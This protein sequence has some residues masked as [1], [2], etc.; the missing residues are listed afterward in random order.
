M[1]SR[2]VG[3]LVEVER[4]WRVWRSLCRI[5]EARCHIQREHKT[6]GTKGCR[7]L[8]RRSCWVEAEAVGSSEAVEHFVSVGSFAA[9]G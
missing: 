2:W 4:G 8:A 9:I 7:H 6:W 3:W 1:S 5:P